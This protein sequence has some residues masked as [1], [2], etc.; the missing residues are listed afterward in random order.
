LHFSVVLPRAAL[1]FSRS[2]LLKRGESVV[3]IRETVKNESP[4][5][6]VFQ[7]QQHAVVGAPFLSPDC[8]VALP[9][10]RGITFPAGYEGRELLKSERDFDWPYAHRFDRGRVD[11]RRVLTTPGRGFVA[12][13]QVAPERSLAFVCVLSPVFR[14]AIGY[15]FRRKDFPWVALWEENGAR[16]SSPW[17]G[18]EK[19]RGIEFGTSP[20]PMMR[21]ENLK[22]GRLF[23][24]STLT[25]VP[26][27]STET[28]SYVLF[29]ARM[30]ETT[31]M[32]RDV[33]VRHDSIDL[34]GA[35]NKPVCSLPAAA[36]HKYL[37]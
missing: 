35:S 37:A 25:R 29:L 17:R 23:G 8:G 28:K 27:K 9:G 26:A 5:D 6:H 2:L 32:I 19:L 7:W 3:Y 31:R 24:T 21:T 13:V 30:P 15:C 11:L 1:S 12:G 14:L 33:A 4:S 36:I 16:Q 20:L 10:A 18:R 22:L 34:L